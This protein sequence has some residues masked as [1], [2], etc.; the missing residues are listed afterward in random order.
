[1]LNSQPKLVVVSGV[2]SGSGKTT[3]AA[4]V[5]SYLQRAHAT[6]AVKLTVTHG[7]QGCPHGGKSCNVCSSLGGDYQII[8]R[9]DI[10]EQ[11]GTD[12]AQ[13]AGAGAS[14]VLWCISR[15]I[16]I[17]KCWRAV[18]QTISTSRF[19]VAES[20]TLAIA[21]EPDLNLM[22]VDP[23]VSR[24]LWKES[25]TRLIASADLVLFNDRGD[26]TRRDVALAETRELRGQ[27]EITIIQ[28]PATSANEPAVT[29]RLNALS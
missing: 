22:I 27:G 3:L 5:I 28:H 10:I 20:N 1:M 19:V 15:D 4:A 18:A 16:A 21:G 8:T 26:P 29:S 17:V 23:T 7:E 6:S 2:A 11:Q 12:T 13:F 25:A 9:R 14:P 24:R